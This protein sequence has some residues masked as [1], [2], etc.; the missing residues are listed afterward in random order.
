MKDNSNKR[1][2][3]KQFKY[4]SAAAKKYDKAK[5]SEADDVIKKKH[6][7]EPQPKPEKENKEGVRLNKF[8]AN[9]GICS[10][11]EADTL[12]S[13]GV[14]KIDGKPVMELGTRVKDGQVVQCG[15]QTINPEQNKYLLLNKPKDYI[16]T[17]TDPQGRKTVMDLVAGSCKERIYPVGRLDR[18]TSGLLLFTNDGDLAKKLTHPKNEVKKVYHVKTDRP[19]SKGDLVQLVKGIELGD[20]AA[21]ADKVGCVGNGEDR[22]EIGVELHSG[23]NRVIRRMFEAL[24]YKVIKLDRT[25]FAGLTKKNLPR[26]K[27]R[28]LDA[29]EIGFLKMI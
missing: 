23:K 29:K 11:R 24:D 17:V 12:I 9:A 4:K 3:G 28:F 26:G 25:V 2:K 15:G 8:L 6:K 27:Y 22:R 1:R 14:V 5:K 13:S 19:V 21:K 20:G 10:R 7:K 18:N 16:T